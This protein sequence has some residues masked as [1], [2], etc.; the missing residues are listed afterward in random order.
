MKRKIIFVNDNDEELLLKIREKLAEL[1]K[2]DESRAKAKEL[3]DS[4]LIR[5]AL[6]VLMNDLNRK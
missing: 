4:Q 5:V 3:T 1:E 2:E 6:K